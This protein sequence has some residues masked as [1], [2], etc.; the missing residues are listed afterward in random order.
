[1]N[2]ND[3]DAFKDYWKSL[4]TINDLNVAIANVN[5]IPDELKPKFRKLQ[6]AWD[7]LEEFLW[8]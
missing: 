3:V 5:A 1:M 8:S 7:D 6:E 4:E 2:L